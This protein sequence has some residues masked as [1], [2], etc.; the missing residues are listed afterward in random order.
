[1]WC[2]VDTSH[3][4]GKLL[5][6]Q[7]YG[8]NN[9]KDFTHN[10]SSLITLKSLPKTDEWAILAGNA[11]WG[12][13]SGLTNVENKK[14]A[15]TDA[16]LCE[17]HL[18]F[19]Y[20]GDYSKTRIVTRIKVTTDANL[21]KKHYDNHEWEDESKFGSRFIKFG[22]FDVEMNVATP[23][24]LQYPCILPVGITFDYLRKRSNFTSREK[25]F[26]ILVENLLFTI[27]IW[28]S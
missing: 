25:E 4:D 17:D 26:I 5:K 24:F 19:Q 21:A 28:N 1:M 22:L 3:T 6:L 23:Y 14:V 13:N 16:N 15:A 18:L 7:Q 9:S 27:W 10:F 11:G 2:V 8:L 12:N 20:F